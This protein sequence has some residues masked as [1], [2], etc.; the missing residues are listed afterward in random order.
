M[1]FIIMLVI[2]LIATDV[3]GWQLVWDALYWRIPS[4][5]TFLENICS[6]AFVGTM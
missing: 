4:E 6:E 3:S 2:S 1:D 5:N